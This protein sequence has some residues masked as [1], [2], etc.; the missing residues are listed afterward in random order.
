MPILSP[1]VGD[2]AACTIRQKTR[3]RAKRPRD[4]YSDGR[5]G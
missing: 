4:P 1:A 2:A 3:E 5:T